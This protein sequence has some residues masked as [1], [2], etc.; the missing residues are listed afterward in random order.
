MYNYQDQEAPQFPPGY[1]PGPQRLVFDGKRMR[2]PIQRKTVDYNSVIVNYVEV[3][4]K[5]CPLC[6]IKCFVDSS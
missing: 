4:K 5:S 3:S 2:K 6:A 1:Q